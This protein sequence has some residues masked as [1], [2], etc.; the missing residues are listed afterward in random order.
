MLQLRISPRSKR[1]K[2]A[3][4]L[5]VTIVAA[6]GASLPDARLYLE[7]RNAAP[8]QDEGARGL[9]SAQQSAAILDELK[10]TSA[11]IDILQKHAALE[12]AIVG[13]PLTPGNKGVLLQE[14][15]ATYK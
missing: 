12:P 4:G 14:S 5:L 10:R 8:L 15:P 11:D 13:S 2:A 6:G 1:V 7:G 3:I 9:L